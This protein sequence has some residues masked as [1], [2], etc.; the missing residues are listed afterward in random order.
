[1]KTVMASENIC[2]GCKA[3]PATQPISEKIHCDTCFNIRHPT[4]YSAPEIINQIFSPDALKSMG[5]DPLFGQQSRC[6]SCKKETSNLKKCG[7]CKSVSY[8]SR[9]CQKQDWSTHKQFCKEKNFPPFPK[10]LVEI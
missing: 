8:C 6:F 4:H 9:A 2:M 3:A 1:M 5:V 10:D 7:K